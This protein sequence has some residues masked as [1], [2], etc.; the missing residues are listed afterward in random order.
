MSGATLPV[1]A[2]GARLHEMVPLI[3]VSRPSARFLRLALQA[4]LAVVWP[5]LFLMPAGGL[6]LSWWLGVL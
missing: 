2:H 5:M 1:L 3:A 6:L 4:S